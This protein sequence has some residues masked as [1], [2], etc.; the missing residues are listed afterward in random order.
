[1][2]NQNLEYLRKE[3]GAFAKLNDMAFLGLF[4]S[5][6]RQEQTKDSDID[7]LVK[8]KTPISLIQL[9]AME[10][11]L[12][13]KFKRKVDL[14]T[15]NALSTHIK[16]YVEKDIIL[17]YESLDTLDILKKTAKLAR[18]KGISL[19]DL[20]LELKGMRDLS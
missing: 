12:S 3:L 13:K 7:L 10:V 19:D 6:A 4:G 15:T 9:I 1:M 20:L 2:N 14:I 11:T 18:E 8:F 16:P 17:I 5:T